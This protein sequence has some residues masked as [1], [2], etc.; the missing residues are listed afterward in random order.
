MPKIPNMIRKYNTFFIRIRV[1]D[2]I[3]EMFGK[4]EVVKSL[5]T[6][7][8]TTASKRIHIERAKIQAEFEEHRQR[9]MANSENR[10]MLSGYS[11]HDLQALS[12]RWLSEKE[13]NISKSTSSKKRLNLSPEEKRDYYT[14]YN[15]RRIWQ[16]KKCAGI[17]KP[18]TMRVFKMP[19]SS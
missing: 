17:V 15:M 3:R 14:T 10:D 1:P 11:D 9:L 18:S 4:T 19:Q 13:E 2:E 12:L 6:K 16:K 8:Y 5:K 7:D